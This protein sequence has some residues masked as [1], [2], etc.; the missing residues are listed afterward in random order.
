MRDERERPIP[1]PKGTSALFGIAWT[2]WAI[3]GTMPGHCSLF[4]GLSGHSPALAPPAI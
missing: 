2:A 3:P 4:T 1:G